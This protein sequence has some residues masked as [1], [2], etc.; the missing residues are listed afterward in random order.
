MFVQ[1]ELSLQIVEAGGAYVWAVKDN[2][3]TLRQDIELLFQPEQTVKGFSP[4][5]KDF[6]T[7]QTV[8]KHHGREERRRLTVSQELKAY[9]D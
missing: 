5:L 3:S 9:L 7:A 6:R 4:A 1:R 2:P 8:E